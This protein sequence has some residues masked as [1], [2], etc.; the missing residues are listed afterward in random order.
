[1]TPSWKAVALPAIVAVAAG[2][3]LVAS[4]PVLEDGVRRC[5]RARISGR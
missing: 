3:L 5:L 1:M 4:L 2:L